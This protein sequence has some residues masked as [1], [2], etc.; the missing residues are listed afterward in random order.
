MTT[1]MIS[2]DSVAPSGPCSTGLRRPWTRH[3]GG[4]PVTAR[5]NT[6]AYQLA[7]FVRRHKLA[8]AAAGLILAL[9]V[10]FAAAMARQAAQ[11]ARQRD[12]AELERD[13]AELVSAFLVDLFELADPGEA[14]GNTITAREVLDR[15]RSGSSGSSGTS[16]RC[17]RGCSTPSAPS[18]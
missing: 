6:L 3:L 17:R 13:K 7:T 5:Q 1:L 18:T 15:G 8:V 12:R 9:V 2:S 11:T 10:A 16:P 4:L 14:K